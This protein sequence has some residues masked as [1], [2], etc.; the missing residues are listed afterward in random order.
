MKVVLFLGTTIVFVYY[1]FFLAITFCIALPKFSRYHG[2]EDCLERTDKVWLVII[3]PFHDMS[4][5]L[6]EELCESPWGFVKMLGTA[7]VEIAILPLSI[8]GGAAYLMI[9]AAGKLSRSL[10]K[11]IRQCRHEREL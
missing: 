5:D 10:T 8:C 3:S 6:V 7:I 11:K 4:N 9:I 2:G 1:V